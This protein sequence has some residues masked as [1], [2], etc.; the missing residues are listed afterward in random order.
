[1]HGTVG[2]ICAL[3]IV[4]MRG[5]LPQSAFIFCDQFSA[6][7]SKSS[8]TMDP[9]TIVGLA[10]SILTFT[11]FAWNLLTNG[12]IETLKSP[13]RQS[14]ADGHVETVVGDLRTMTERLANLPLAQNGVHEIQL[15]KLAG[16]CAFECMT[17]LHLLASQKIRGGKRAIGR[18]PRLL[19]MT[20]HAGPGVQL[21]HHTLHDF[22][23]L[24][25]IG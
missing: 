11:D 14:N 25:Q 20:S 23:Y 18:V 6:I 10:A 9:V 8:N 3:V 12:S 1:M 17:L 5:A 4:Q 7:V 24:S 16:T 21:F 13:G 22:F 2:Q 15:R 19:E